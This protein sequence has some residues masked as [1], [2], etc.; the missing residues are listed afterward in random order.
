MLTEVVETFVRCAKARGGK[1]LEKNIHHTTLIHIGKEFSPSESFE[2]ATDSFSI[3]ETKEGEILNIPVKQGYFLFLFAPKSDIDAF[4]TLFSAFR[5]KLSNAIDACL[6]VEKLCHSNLSLSQQIDKEKSRN[7][8]TEK[9]MISQSRL[10]IMGEMI[11]MIAHQWRQPITLI[12][13]LTN[14]TL[15]DV[16]LGDIKEKQLI[17]DL[18]LI[19]KQIHFLSRTIDDF[20]NFFRPN[21]LPKSVTFGEIGTE[22]TT[23]MGKSFLNRRISLIFEGND[24]TPFITYKNEL[25]QVFINILNNSKDAFADQNTEYPVIRFHLDEN[26]SSFLFFISDNAGGIPQTIIS[27]IFEPYFSTKSEKNG[28]GLGLYMSAIIVERHLR[29]SII[30]CSDEKGTTFAVKIPKNG[31]KKGYDVY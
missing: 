8:A 22:L 19:D 18:Q 9:L 1:Y 10:A 11:G 25:L 20:R 17:S 4:A 30:A 12:G 7:H 13:M 29:G 3:H 14:N 28:T 24:D 15:L 5:T 21:K 27:R 23:I 6:S 2:Y 16:Q 31:P 26:E